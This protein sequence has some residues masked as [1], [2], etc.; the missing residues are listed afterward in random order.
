M[1]TVPTAKYN[2][3]FYKLERQT[4][5]IKHKTQKSVVS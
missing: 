2:G 4:D 1:V 3:I 5:I